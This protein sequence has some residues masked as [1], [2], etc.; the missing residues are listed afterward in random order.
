MCVYTSNQKATDVKVQL[1]AV[2][3]ILVFTKL[4]QIDLNGIKLR[5]NRL[6]K[7]IKNKVK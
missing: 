5:L 7:K 6:K 2:F 1:K 4:N 3:V